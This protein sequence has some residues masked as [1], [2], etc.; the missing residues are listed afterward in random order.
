VKALL[1]VISHYFAAAIKLSLYL[2]LNNLTVIFSV[3]ACFWFS[4]AAGYSTLESGCSLLL[5]DLGNVRSL[6]HQQNVLPFSLLYL[7]WS[8]LME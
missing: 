5:L 4:L 6:F 3:W 1:Y 8:T 7:D 2:T